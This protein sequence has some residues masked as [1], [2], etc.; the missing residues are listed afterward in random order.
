MLSRIVVF[1][2]LVFVVASVHMVVASRIEVVEA[3]IEI[4]KARIEGIEA[5]IEEVEA[6]I[7]EVV[8]RIEGVVS[9]IDGDRVDFVD[10]IP[11]ANWIDFDEQV[12]VCLEVTVLAIFGNFA[13][14]F[15]PFWCIECK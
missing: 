10:E 6:R 9:K 15:R 14:A 7:E 13:S 2:V 3:R 11:V 8:A 12:V 1:D 4:V 5:R